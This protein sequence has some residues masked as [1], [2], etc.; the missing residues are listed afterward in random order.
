MGFYDELTSID[1]IAPIRP[2]LK[3]M[4]LIYHTETQKITRGDLSASPDHPFLH[5]VMD[6]EREC[7]RWWH[8]YLQNYQLVSRHCYGCW[9]VVAIPRT[10]KEL[11]EI[12]ELQK[13]LGIPA[14]CGVERRASV[15]RNYG[16]YW[17]C[18]LKEGLGQ[19]RVVFKR[20][21]RA[22]HEEV[23][24]DIKVFLKRACTEMEDLKGDSDKW[25][26]TITDQMLEDLL[27][28]V[29]DLPQTMNH[30]DGPFEVHM[31][32]TWI[33]F[34]ASH[35][36]PTVGEF[37]AHKWGVPYIEYQRSIH[38]PQDFKGGD[39]IRW[40]VK[41]EVDGIKSKVLEQY[42]RSTPVLSRLTN[43]KDKG[44]DIHSRE[45]DYRKLDLTT[46]L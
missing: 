41:G 29:F 9:K 18:P 31:V 35:G 14:K 46:G 40:N 34:A 19:A 44:S 3:S 20:I 16:A 37:C 25:E 22:I 36:D 10:L 12:K 11:L 2:K 30:T 42:E 17:Y 38:R 13:R 4:E 23:A 27:D 7:F 21:E 28:A 8:V 24:S 43:S 32:R 6:E 15:P 5:T 1:I 33:E 45:A 39:E 26:Y